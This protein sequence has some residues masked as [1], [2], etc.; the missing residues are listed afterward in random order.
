[1]AR[2]LS[3]IEPG[4]REYDYSVSLALWAAMTRDWTGAGLEREVHQEL[5]SGQRLLG[6]VFLPWLKLPVPNIGKDRDIRPINYVDA[7]RTSSRVVEAGAT[8]IDDHTAEFSPVKPQRIRIEASLPLR[9]LNSEEESDEMLL[10]IQLMDIVA[11]V[12]DREALH[13][14][15]EYQLPQG[16]ATLPGVRRVEGGEN[17]VQPTRAH[18]TQ[19]TRE[20]S[21][22]NFDDASFAYITNDKVKAALK[23]TPATGL[24]AR[25]GMMVWESGPRPL[26]GR[27]GLT[28][29]RVR[30]NLDKGTSK[31]ACSAIFYGNWADLLVGRWGAIDVKIIPPTDANQSHVEVVIHVDIDVAVTREESFAV[32]KDALT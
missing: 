25:E 18:I 9:L 3:T 17:G 23:K 16:I 8:V 28:T 29:D 31:G 20:I 13:G 21:T 11:G 19:L 5:G 14:L 15:G 1:V 10:R 30:S 7:M 27:P 6:N 4:I 22:D 12:I 2:F 26:N 32:M 24:G